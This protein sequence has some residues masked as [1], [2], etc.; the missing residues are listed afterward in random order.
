MKILMVLTQM[1]FPCKPMNRNHLLSPFFWFPLIPWFELQIFVLKVRIPYF[2]R[3]DTDGGST[4]V[5]IS[6]NLFT[7]SSRSILNTIE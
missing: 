4:V 1:F 5:N 2:Y 3:D 6:F 7:L